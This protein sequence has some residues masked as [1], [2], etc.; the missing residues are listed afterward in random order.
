[1][2]YM[3]LIPYAIPCTV[4]TIYTVYHIYY[5][6]H[7]PYLLYVLYALCSFPNLSDIVSIIN[8]YVRTLCIIMYLCTCSCYALS[9]LSIAQHCIDIETAQAVAVGVAVGAAE[10]GTQAPADAVAETKTEANTEAAAEA[11]AGVGQ[12]I[13]SRSRSRHVYGAEGN[14][15]QRTSSVYNIGAD[16]VLRAVNY[17]S[18]K[19]C[20][21]NELVTSYT[22][23][24]QP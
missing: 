15:L 12:I 20:T 5:M 11:E 6:S 19:P 18:S 17:F 4:Y 21:H 1:M 22:A 8:E 24:A 3:H 23:T 2:Y 9:G 7:V 10:A 16:K 14:G 13:P